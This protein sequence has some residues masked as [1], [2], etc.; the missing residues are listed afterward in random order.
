MQRTQRKVKSPEIKAKKAQKRKAK[1]ATQ[2]K[3][4]KAKVA[5][6]TREYTVQAIIDQNA[7]MLASNRIANLEKALELAKNPPAP[8]QE[9]VLTHDV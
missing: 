8:I 7:L 1:I 4:I 5:K 2:T 6:L 9:G 3:K